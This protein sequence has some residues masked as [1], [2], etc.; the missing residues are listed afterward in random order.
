MRTMSE[1]NFD[2]SWQYNWFMTAS[3]VFIF[4]VFSINGSAA[5]TDHFLHLSNSRKSVQDYLNGWWKK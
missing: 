1:N 5:Q 4:A 3:K 2:R